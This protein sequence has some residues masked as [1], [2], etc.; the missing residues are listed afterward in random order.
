MQEDAR[1]VATRSLD[2]LLA[3]GDELFRRDTVESIAEATQIYQLAAQIL[4]NPSDANDSLLT[5]RQT[6]ADRLFKLRHCMNIEGVP[7]GNVLFAPPIDPALLVSAKPRENPPPGDAFLEKVVLGEIEGKNQA[8]HFYDDIVWKIRS[9]F[10]TLLLGGW[11]IVLKGF[12]EAPDPRIDRYRG[13]V[14]GLLLFSVAFAFGAWHVDRAYVRRRFRVV[15][16]LNRLIEELMANGGNLKRVTTPN[17][18]VVG[19]NPDVPFES[20]GY[21][22]ARSTE[23][24]VYLAPLGLL[25]VGVFLVLT[26]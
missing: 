17:L 19:D 2:D 11:A 21:R 3:T 1:A 5:Y 26:Y 6:I 8:L 10:L 13:L 4:G 12:V 7:R 22:Q 14:G 16:A 24:A 20:P 18:K 25:L 9:G 23:F 15:H